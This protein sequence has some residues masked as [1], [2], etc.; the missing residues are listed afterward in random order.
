MPFDREEVHDALD[1]LVGVIRVQCCDAE[2]SGFCERDG[3]F[4]SFGIPDFTDENHVGGLPEGVLQ[5][6][7]KIQGVEAYLALRDRPEELFVDTVKR[8]GVEPFK[9]RVYA[10]R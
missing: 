10:T 9:E 3:G 7:L 4:H 8:L 1:G 2:V 5:R 6:I